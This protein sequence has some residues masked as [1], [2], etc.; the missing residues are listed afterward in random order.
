[1]LKKG[2]SE[3][4]RILK[5]NGVLI[6]KWCE[7]Q[8]PLKKILA[9]TKEKPLFGHKSGKAMKTHWVVFIKNSLTSTCSG[10]ADKAPQTT[11]V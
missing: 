11:D 6:F 1:M 8:F 7:V 10:F 9:L 4:F 5:P 2:F 3:C